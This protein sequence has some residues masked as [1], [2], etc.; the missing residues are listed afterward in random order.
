MNSFQPLG[1]G[2]GRPIL[3]PA[4]PAESND[5]PDTMAKKS[6]S[7]GDTI[8]RLIGEAGGTLSAADLSDKMPD[9]A[10]ANR[11]Y[12]VRK[13]VQEGRLTAAG[14]TVDRSYSLAGT[15]AKTAKVTVKTPAKASKPDA[16]AAKAVRS[17]R[18]RRERSQCSTRR[19]N[20]PSAERA[21]RY[22]HRRR[23][24]ATRARGPAQ[25]HD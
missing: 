3:A 20:G 5:E 25:R 8:L 17:V 23:D 11:G 16:P 4:S 18:A 19:A 7:I 6:E 15:P 22:Q 21:A 1:C 2:F 10:D 14:K 24:R 12:H 9:V 13:L